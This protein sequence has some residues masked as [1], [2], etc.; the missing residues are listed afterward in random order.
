MVLDNLEDDQYYLFRKYGELKYREGWYLACYFKPVNHELLNA[1][2][3]NGSKEFSG[4]HYQHPKKND[5]KVLYISL[6]TMNNF[7]LGSI[8]KKGEGLVYNTK[9][10]FQKFK[11]KIYSNS[12]LSFQDQGI[13]IKGAQNYFNQYLA[14]NDDFEVRSFY[15]NKIINVKHLCLHKT[16]LTLSYLFRTSSLVKLFTQPGIDM[17]DTLVDGKFYKYTNEDEQRIITVIKNKEKVS[18]GK[19]AYITVMRV[20]ESKLFRE[21]VTKD[22]K[23]NLNEKL[24]Q[25]KDGKSKKE[26][27]LR[28]KLCFDP[29]YDNP[30]ELEVY[31]GSF[32]NLFEVMGIDQCNQDIGFDQLEILDNEKEYTRDP[33]KE[34]Y[35][36]PLILNKANFENDLNQDDDRSGNNT[37]E[38]TV[39]SVSIMGI[40]RPKTRMKKKVT[41][42]RGNGQYKIVDVKEYDNKSTNEDAEPDDKTKNID[43]EGLRK[44]YKEYNFSIS[45]SNWCTELIK[46]LDEITKNEKVP[47]DFVGI[48]SI[49]Y[50]LNE[51]KVRKLY[52]STMILFF[53]INLK[54][55]GAIYYFEKLGDNGKSRGVLLWEEE[56]KELKEIKPRVSFNK[57]HSATNDNNTS[58]KPNKNS[59]WIYPYG[60]GSKLFCRRMNVQSLK[61]KPDETKSNKDLLEL[62]VKKHIGKII[63]YAKK[64]SLPLTK[65]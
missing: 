5:F 8:F 64:N 39:S 29:S 62:T 49:D 20:L 51:I 40:Q 14:Y 48:N 50:E 59:L 65:G 32:N 15:D 52:G 63:Q 56:G 37:P 13:E 30:I 58:W 12:T 19:E 1:E 11:I 44:R 53:Q 45:F 42:S 16:G 2:V 55:R 3:I 61:T 31:G 22:I 60:S 28:G 33:K 9:E 17:L 34:P 35:E 25:Y 10:I 54:D 7:P 27:H 4:K 43:I 47:I 46:Q 23:L 26:I 36:I 21:F 38:Q 57:I 18:I 41:Q 24:K 6:K